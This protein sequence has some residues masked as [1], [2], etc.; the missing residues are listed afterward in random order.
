MAGRERDVPEDERIRFRIGINL[1]DVV[2]ED[3]DVYG[4]GVNIAARLEQLCEP[5]GVVV[6]GTAYDHL[7][8]KLDLP[9]DFTGEHR[10]K[11]IER[12]IRVYRVRLEGGSLAKRL[13]R[14]PR[15]R[16][17]AVSTVAAVT[18]LAV[19]A[20]GAWWLK[21]DGPPPPV[22]ASLAVLPF[23]NYGG[24]EATGRLA[25][26]LTE[27]VITDLARFR[28]LHV[29]AR[30]ST[31]TYKGRPVDV[32]Q[33]G[34]DL[35]V[36]YVLEGSIQRQSDR[37]RV[38]AQLIDAGSGEHVWSDRW[39]RPAADVFAVQTEL[40]ERVAAKLGGYTGTVVGADR[41]AAKRK[42]PADLTAYDLYLLG[43][44]A[45]HRETKESVEE[46]VR[47]LKRSVEI[48]PTF[49]R[50]WTGLA[51]CYT[52]LG[53]WADD[54]IELDR[55]RLD[56]ARRAVEIDPV[57]AEAH[58][59]LA[60]AVG[61]GGDLTR[62]EVEYDKALSLNPNSA[63]ILS[64]YA[65]WASSFGEPGK[66]VEAA[67]RAI[68]LNPNMPAW[69]LGQYRYAYFMVGRYKEAL[70]FI[71]RRPRENWRP[72]DYVLRAASLA[73]LGR[74]DDARGAVA[75]ALAHFPVVTVEGYAGTP[76]YLGAERERLT[77]TMRAAGFP[78]CARPENAAKWLAGHVRLPECDAER[79]KAVA[80]RS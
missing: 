67:E 78:L 36:R 58:A 76:D 29:I 60:E 51:W 11:N 8:G 4:D 49:A 14:A 55:L 79:A 30:N 54:T 40:A 65:G 27:D 38:T 5:G 13:P 35:N 73:A 71:E 6:S 1:G 57:D 23:D 9:L 34:K 25:D 45:K 66:G 64:W 52:M 43:I 16:R 63:D 39:D 18:A 77:E 42:R 75:D 33:V 32:R 19:L 21:T 17:W 69:A 70:R 41:D 10:V 12:P 22:A 50:A 47:L 72:T 26:G 3:G 2:H 53:S 31:M 7:Q 48:D 80:G 15:P 44:E 37:V 46:A 59:V 56:A 24:D 61:M 62:A 68:R 28:D 74:A 20:G